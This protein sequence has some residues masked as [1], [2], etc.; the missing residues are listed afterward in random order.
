MIIG[1][2]RRDMKL[3][4]ASKFTT[5]VQAS[6]ANLNEK[7]AY[8]ADQLGVPVAIAKI[9]SFSVV[10]EKDHDTYI[11]QIVALVDFTLEIGRQT[12]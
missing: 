10:Q 9:E 2:H 11:Y 12:K 4:L 7:I 1:D 8:Q 6:I 5:L 3:L